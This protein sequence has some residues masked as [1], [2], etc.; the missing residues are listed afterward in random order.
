[1]PLPQIEDGVGRR[2]LLAPHALSQHRGGL[3]RDERP[4]QPQVQEFVHE[5]RR[6]LGRRT[7]QPRLRAREQLARRYQLVDQTDLECARAFV[8]FAFEHEIECGTHPDELYA[9]H[10]AAESRM[11][12]EQYLGQPQGQL[13]VVRSHSIGAGEREFQTAAEREAVQCRN[14]G[15][16]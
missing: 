2:V 9:A 1:M 8:R 11:D 16:G 15:A 5:R 3:P 6:C 4:R 10:R 14:R 13:G 12:A 7:E